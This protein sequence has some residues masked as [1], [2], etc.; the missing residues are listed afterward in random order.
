MCRVG[1]TTLQD[2]INEPRDGNMSGTIIGPA[3]CGLRV[4]FA[5]RQTPD[6]DLSSPP[7]LGVAL[8]W[9]GAPGM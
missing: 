9:L 3:G 1:F 5:A 8:R 7:A 6:D 2:D 4:V